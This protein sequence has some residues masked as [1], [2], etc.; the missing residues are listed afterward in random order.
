MLPIHVAGFLRLLAILICVNLLGCG[1]AHSPVAKVIGTVTYQGQPATGGRVLFL[2]AGGGKQG[3]GS[4]E[5]DGTF[6]LGTF[7][8]NDGALIGNH[9]AILVRVAFT[10]RGDDLLGFRRAEEQ[11][12]VVEADKVNEFKFD[13][14]SR[15]WQKLSD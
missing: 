4:I 10:S 5:P 15:E 6:E 1:K 11:R 7:S 3:L 8:A 12:I 13:L 2:P 9:H 14:G